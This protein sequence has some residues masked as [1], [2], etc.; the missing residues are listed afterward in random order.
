MKHRIALG[1]SYAGG[2]IDDLFAGLKHSGVLQFSLVGREVSVQ[3]NEEHLDDVKKTL[4]HLGVENLQLLEWRTI[5]LTVSG[6][7]KGHDD[8]KDVY[9]SLIP[10]AL[11]EGIR[12]LRLSAPPSVDSALL[13]RTDAHL[14]DIV[15]KAG[16]TDVL[17]TVQ[18][19]GELADDDLL[20][21]V[22]EAT[23]E[24]LFDGGGLIS[25]E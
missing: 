18:V 13:S 15:A 1:G 23:L 3:V 6:S 11:G 14:R 4:K 22:E 20:A 12:C 16:A 8:G 9:V 10:T 5:P 7:G 24:A 25:V 2:D 19:F 17:Y 21:A